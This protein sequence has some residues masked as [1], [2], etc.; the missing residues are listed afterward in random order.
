MDSTADSRP[1]FYLDDLEVGQKFE[2]GTYLMEEARMKAFAAEFDPQPFHLDEAAANDSV[3]GGL[4]ASGWHTAA[5]T[6]RLIVGGPFKL[7]GGSVGLGG[8][9]AWPR[10]TRAGDVLR[11]RTEIIEIV[12]SRS[13]PNQGIVKIRNI[14]VNQKGDEVQVFTAKLMVYKR[15]VPKA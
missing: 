8:E 5:A 15:P 4:A 6:M 12:P 7:A 1:I 13:K 14:T 11:V 2:T 10:P 3:F 9:I